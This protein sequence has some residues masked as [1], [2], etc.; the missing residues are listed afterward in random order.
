M[1]VGVKAA[2]QTHNLKEKGSNPLSATRGFN[3]IG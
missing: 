3:L 2:R 1:R